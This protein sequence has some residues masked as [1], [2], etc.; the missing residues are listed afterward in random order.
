MPEEHDTAEVEGLDERDQIVDAPGEPVALR[1]GG[2][3]G[4]AEPDVVRDHDT[5]AVGEERADELPVKEAPG[6]VPVE[7]EDRP[8]LALVHVRHPEARLHLVEPR[9]PGV[10]PPDDW[11]P[12]LEIHRSPP[13]RRDASAE[14]EMSFSERTSDLAVG[15]AG[16]RSG[17]AEVVA[18]GW[19]IRLRA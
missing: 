2:L 15:M 12:M 4:P 13:Q 6:R 7:Q 9:R 3:V 17:A 8:A 19:Y 11:C 10:L 5:A 14:P 1:V 16:G 18:N